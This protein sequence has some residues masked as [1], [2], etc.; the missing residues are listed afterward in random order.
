MPSTYC[1]CD[2]FTL[3][4]MN[5]TFN[6]TNATTYQWQSSPVGQHIWT[7]INHTSTISTIKIPYQVNSMDYRCIIYTV[8]LISENFISASITVLTTTN[9]TYCPTRII[10]C[11]WGDGIDNFT[12]FG[13]SNTIIDD[14]DT[15]CSI[16]SYDNRTSESVSLYLNKNYTAQ[17]SSLF[18]ADQILVIWID[19]NNNFNFEMWE[20]ISNQT[21]N[22]TYLTDVIVSIPSSSVGATIGTHRMRATAIYEEIPDSCSSIG[23]YGETHDYTVNILAATG[24]L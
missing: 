8:N 15:G 13:E 1:G 14:T 19:F 6:A 9:T 12:L 22:S 7:N 4:L 17:V 2:G 24:R 21:L 20:C 23:V 16:N 5:M 11:F 18:P 3:S 10:D